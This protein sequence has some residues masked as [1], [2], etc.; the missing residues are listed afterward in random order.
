MS[1]GHNERQTVAGAFAKIEAHEEI[2]AIRYKQIF[3]TLGELKT[4]AKWAAGGIAGLALSLIA[5]MGSQMFDAN[6]ARLTALEGAPS[7][8]VVVNQP[9]AK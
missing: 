5:W 4:I 8:T 9:R 2:C 6:D 7:Q 3:D 1:D